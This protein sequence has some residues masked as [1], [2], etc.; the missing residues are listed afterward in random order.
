MWL[1]SPFYWF[2]SSGAKHFPSQTDW[3]PH[4]GSILYTAQCSERKADKLILPHSWTL[5]DCLFMV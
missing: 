1:Q 5:T 2:Q 4:F 3:D